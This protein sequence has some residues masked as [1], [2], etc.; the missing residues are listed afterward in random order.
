[1][2]QKKF[3]PPNWMIGVILALLF[4]LI[5]AFTLIGFI[6]GFEAAPPLK[7]IVAW[8]T[9]IIAGAI[10]FFLISAAIFDVVIAFIKKSYHKKETKR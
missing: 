6:V 1:M 7:K 3:R 8:T 10:G 4:I 5:F 2:N 9:T